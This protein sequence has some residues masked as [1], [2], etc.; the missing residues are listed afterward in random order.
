MQGNILGQAGG[1]L[2]LKGILK[3]YEVASGGKVRAGDFVK[4][5]NEA[6]RVGNYRTNTVSNANILNYNNVKVRAVALENNKIFIAYSQNQCLYGMVCSLNGDILTQGIETLIS[7]NPATSY[8]FSISYFSPTSVFI[9]YLKNTGQ[10]NNYKCPLYGRICSIDN[11]NITLGTENIVTLPDTQVLSGSELFMSYLTENKILI[12]NNFYYSSIGS[13]IYATVCTITDSSIIAGTTI[14]M[15]SDTITDVKRLSDNSVCIL[16]SGGGLSNYYLLATILKIEG[17]VITKGT[18][19]QLTTVK[20]TGNGAKLET[21][22]E[23]KILIAHSSGETNYCHAMVC[24]ISGT[25]ITK[26]NDTL[27]NNKINTWNP[28][29]LIKI[30]ENNAFII[31]VAEDEENTEEKALYGTTCNIS[32]RNIT[33]GKTEKISDSYFEG[34]YEDYNYDSVLLDNIYNY[35]IFFDKHINGIPDTIKIVSTSVGLPHV[36]T[37]NSKDDIILGIAK[38]KGKEDE[39]IK[40]YVPKLPEYISTEEG[41]RIITENGEE[42]RNE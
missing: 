29:S 41:N 8:T 11:Y 20:N 21:L 4:Y 13:N 14:N 19:T 28:I 22:N 25:T 7:D 39:K 33:L 17:N 5:I 24:T 6:V 40:I 16:N 27:I 32:N 35:T 26:G 31:Y 2:N 3:E 18:K 10:E 12:L 37:I 15:S 23:D 42:I 9:G 34:F 36:S 1:G 38:T 30:S